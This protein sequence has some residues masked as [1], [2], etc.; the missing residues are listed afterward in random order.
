MCR[1]DFRMILQGAPT[2]RPRTRY[3]DPGAPA[4]RA[5]WRSPRRP[6]RRQRPHA[7]DPARRPATT[8]PS[9]TRSACLRRP[10]EAPRWRSCVHRIA[11]PACAGLRAVHDGAPRA[12]H[13]RRRHRPSKGPYPCGALPDDT[14]AAPPDPAQCTD[15]STTEVLELPEDIAGWEEC[16]IEGTRWV[17]LRMC[18]AGG[19]IGCCDDSPDRHAT[20][21]FHQTGHPVIGSAESGEDWRCCYEDELVSRL[22]QP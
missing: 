13:E 14:P 3:G 17:H 10:P 4:A 5:P 15:P 18:R 8:A 20:R 6:R 7:F 1:H 11:R 22:G 2:A 12:Q 21:H 19:H 16:L 9:A